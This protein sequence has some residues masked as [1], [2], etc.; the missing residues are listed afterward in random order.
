MKTLISAGLTALALCAAAPAFAAPTNALCL[1][2]S[3]VDPTGNTKRWT[4]A[5]LISANLASQCSQKLP[6]ASLE[7]F[8]NCAKGQ[9]VMAGKYAGQN[10]TTLK[11]SKNEIAT[12]TSGCAAAAG[13]IQPWTRTQ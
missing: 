12:A 4:K 8:A 13:T 6:A 10:F 9:A 1:K 5:E 11:F 3:V 7:L 2:L